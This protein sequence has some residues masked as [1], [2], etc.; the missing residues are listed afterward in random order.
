MGGLTCKIGTVQYVL[1][2]AH[3]FKSIHDFDIN[4]LCNLHSDVHRPISFSI[5]LDSLEEDR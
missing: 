3:M 2:N 1:S 5:L 4:E